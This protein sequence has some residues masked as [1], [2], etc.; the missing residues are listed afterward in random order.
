MH[1]V[2]LFDKTW[3]P[4]ED[5]RMLLSKDKNCFNWMNYIN[6]LYDHHTESTLQETDF[7]GDVHRFMWFEIDP[8]HIRSRRRFRKNRYPE[9]NML[10]YNY[11]R[12]LKTGLG[13]KRFYKRFVKVRKDAEGNEYLDIREIMF[14]YPLYH[15]RSNIALNWIVSKCLQF[16][17]MKKV[18]ALGLFGRLGLATRMIL[19][20]IIILPKDYLILPIWI[21]YKN[22]IRRL[23][24]KMFLNFIGM[25][26][27]LQTWDGNRKET[28]SVLIDWD[29]MKKEQEDRVLRYWDHITHARTPKQYSKAKAYMRNIINLYPRSLF[30][31][32]FTIKKLRHSLNYSKQKWKH[33]FD[34]HYYISYTNEYHYHH[35]WGMLTRQGKIKNSFDTR[36]SLNYPLCIQQIE[37][38]PNYLM[39]LQQIKA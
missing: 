31:K 33:W 28:D 9:L 27:E 39:Y 3:L 18:R 1:S 4:N 34:L 20:C 10:R 16:L 13:Y 12:Y 11:L 30:K 5:K 22:W 2:P 17:N 25:S 6:M 36:L 21:S 24:P 38:E 37:A 32:A 26:T 8:F 14:L 29:R 35:R 7:E 23:A 19:K 15:F